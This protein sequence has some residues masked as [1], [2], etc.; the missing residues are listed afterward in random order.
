MRKVVVL[1]A[2]L[3]P[4]RPKI[5]PR[6]DLEAD[7]IDRSEGPEPPDQV[8]DLDDHFVAVSLRRPLERHGARKGSPRGR[9]PTQQDHE[10]VFEPWLRRNDRRALKR[11]DARHGGRPQGRPCTNRTCPPSGTAS[12][13][14]RVVEQPRLQPARRLP[15]GRLGKKRPAGRHLG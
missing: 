3:G 6:S 2:P 1:P 5:S 15:R 9:C 14:P 13:M 7:M 8:V 4:S 12:T 10:A 11:A